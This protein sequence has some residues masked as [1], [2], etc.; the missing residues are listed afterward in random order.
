M[1]L[2]FIVFFICGFFVG[3]GQGH[4]LV[5][6][7][8]DSIPQIRLR[9][10]EK[11]PAQEPLKGMVASRKAESEGNFSA[12]LKALGPA[13]VKTK[14]VAPWIQLSRLRCAYQLDG[15]AQT[16][17]TL[18]IVRSLEKNKDW[19]MLGPYS[20]KL[21]FHV[22]EA[23]FAVLDELVKRDRAEAAKIGEELLGLTDWMD[24]GQ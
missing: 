10:K 22:I 17:E 3:Q 4:A 11:P 7:I 20:G 13:V 19:F 5:L 1:R 14:S 2:K 23:R 24:A 18:K 12:C 9:P 16:D 8:Q 6:S 21:R 15:R